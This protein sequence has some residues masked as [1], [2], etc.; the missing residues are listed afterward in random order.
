M[1]DFTRADVA[2]LLRRSGFA[3]LPDDV[4]ALVG[5]ASWADVVDQVLDPTGS[6]PDTIPAIVADPDAPQGTAGIAAIRY[7]V[8]RMVSTPTP[9]VER[10]A[11]FWHGIL[12]SALGDALPLWMHRQIQTWRKLGLGDIH[13]L[14]QAMAKDPA[15]LDYLDNADNTKASPNENFARELME[16]FT[17]GNFTYTEAD[18]IGMAR[19]WTGHNLAYAA[20]AYVFRPNQ[21]DTG[22]K[23]I[24]GI[25][26]NWDGPDTI[27]EIVRGSKQPVCARYLAGRIWSHFAHPDPSSGL[28][29]ELAAALIDLDMVVQPFLKV[30]FERP[31]FRSD[32]TRRGLVRSPVEWE[33]AVFKATGLGVDALDLVN[34]QRQLGQVPLL[35]PNVSGWRQNG[36]WISSSAMWAKGTF[37]GMLRQALIDEGTFDDLKALSTAT[38]VAEALDRFGVDQPTAATVGHLTDFLTAERAAGRGATAP[39][40]LAALVTLTPDFQLA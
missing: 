30:V 3:S 28:L 29:D 1:A 6:P 15:M 19:A 9:I 27:T 39:A 37:A 20:G 25:T 13:A 8:E 17:M 34:I 7:W 5:E 40:T 14:M 31:E 36:A 26:K 38:A 33:V 12:T 24:F 4:D 35:P 11:W 10:T 23:T 22:Q 18:V 32:A 21:H 16:L 2:L